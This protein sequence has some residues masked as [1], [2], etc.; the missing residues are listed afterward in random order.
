MNDMVERILNSYQLMRPLDVERVADS[1][2]KL[3]DI[4]K[5]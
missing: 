5:T 3:A 1:R 4:S 2:K